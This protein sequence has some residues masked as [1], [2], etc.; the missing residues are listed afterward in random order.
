MNKL[1]HLVLGMV[2]AS[3]GA[4][5]A[6]AAGAQ[7]SSSQVTNSSATI[8]QPIQLAKNT[9]LSFG[10]IVRP[11]SGSGTVTISSADGERTYTGGVAL[12]NSGPNAPSGRAT[13]T[14]TGEGGQSMN[15]NIPASFSMTRTGGSETITVTLAM[16]VTN[17]QLLSGTL[18]NTGNL[19]F[20]VGGSIPVA[21]STHSGAYTGTFN[22]VVAY[23]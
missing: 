13:Y 4:A 15:V 8:F 5:L 1:R 3:A 16:S 11:T 14:V 7:A 17:P 22:V 18:G 9:D 6:T 20:G 23:N 19:T 12:L 10:T 21:D 2:A